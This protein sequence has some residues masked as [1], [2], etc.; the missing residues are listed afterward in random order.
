MPTPA[1]TLYDE[2]AYR[3][4]PMPQ[5]HPDRLATIGLLHGLAS[6]PVDGEVG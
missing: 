5:T 3:T 4:L 6:R 2:V 1:S